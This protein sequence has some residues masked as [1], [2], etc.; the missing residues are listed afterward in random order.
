LREERLQN[1]RKRQ[2]DEAAPKKPEKKQK[3]SDSKP[4]SKAE[5][6]EKRASP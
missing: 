2:R 3:I 4:K 1:I 5:N 6:K